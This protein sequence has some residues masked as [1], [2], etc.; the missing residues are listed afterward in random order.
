MDCHDSPAPFQIRFEV[1]AVPACNVSG[2]LGVEDKDVGF[3]KLFR[4]GKFVTAGGFCTAAVEEFR[5]V[6]QEGGMVVG[7]A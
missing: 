2:F 1:F 7:L 3:R 5:P 4:C 6:P